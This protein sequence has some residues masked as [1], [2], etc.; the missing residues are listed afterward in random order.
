MSCAGLLAQEK[1]AVFVTGDNKLSENKVFG[2]RFVAALEKRNDIKA[3]EYTDNFLEQLASDFAYQQNG[4]LSCNK[5]SQIGKQLGTDLVCVI[6][7]SNIF[8]EKYISAKLISTVT[9]EIIKQREVTAVWK[10]INGLIAATQ[11]LANYM[12]QNKKSNGK[13]TKDIVV[14]KPKPLN[15]DFEKYEVMPYDLEGSYS[16]SNAKAACVNLDVFGENDWFLPNKEELN[17]MYKQKVEIGGF[18]EDWY[19]SCDE[20]ESNFYWLQN[21]SDGYQGTTNQ[22]FGRKVRCIRKK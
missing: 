7:I 17:A 16:W 10:D 13:G 3:V 20:A 2:A 8:N 15:I 19:W 6:E 22:S 1:V 14:E 12:F 11:N 18:S 4:V 5:V 9:A 21:F